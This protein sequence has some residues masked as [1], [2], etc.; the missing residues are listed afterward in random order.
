[1]FNN[2]T[3]KL[4]EKL[5][6]KYQ[7]LVILNN[8]INNNCNFSLI[9]S[10]NDELL[11]DHL[12]ILLS[13]NLLKLKASGYFPTEKG[14][15][16]IEQLSQKLYRYREFYSLFSAVDLGE[17][18]FGYANYYDYDSDEEF[19]EYINEERFEDLR[20]AVAIFK[21]I[22]PFEITFLELIDEDRFNP[23]HFENWQLDLFTDDIWR[24]MEE[25]VQSAIKPSDLYE[26]DH[27][28]DEVMEIII[29]NG[30]E[31]SKQLLQIEKESEESECI[32]SNEQ[33]EDDY[34]DTV[35]VEI[36]YHYDPYYVESYWY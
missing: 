2:N 34:T 5:M 11:E 28:G 14:R 15:Q 8:I 3:Y 33:K 17:G 20:I 27:T 32:D 18:S 1:M 7:S 29:N 13:D 24:D 25:I 36:E 12:G 35:I 16:E 30:V 4:E 31:V 10:G 23:A 26:E 19:I 6:K 9:L 21:K 22:N